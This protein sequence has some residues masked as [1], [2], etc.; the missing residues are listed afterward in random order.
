[1]PYLTVSELREKSSLDSIREAAESANAEIQFLIEYC[2]ALIDSYVGYSFV[3][4]PDRVIYT[5]GE[6]TST[7][8]LHKRIYNIISIKDSS[9]YVYDINSMRIADYAKNRKIINSRERFED[10]VENI[11]VR[12]DFGWPVVPD[13]V[14]MCLV[15]L[16]NGNYSYLSD[17][18]KMQQAMGPFKSE[19]IGNYSYDLKNKVNSV[20]GEEIDTTGDTRVDLILNKYK[21]DNFSIGVV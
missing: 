9:G 6:G 10:G 11:E 20:T 2:T 13:D 15:L 4:E 16:C 17:E 12:G 3:N 19:K 5:D 18:D 21:S 1:M 14:V 8:A 7:I